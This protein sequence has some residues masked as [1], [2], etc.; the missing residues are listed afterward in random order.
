MTSTALAFNCPHFFII[1]NRLTVG[2]RCYWLAFPQFLSKKSP[3]RNRMPLW[4]DGIVPCNASFKWVNYFSL[5]SVFAFGYVLS[6]PG[7][8]PRDY[9]MRRAF[10]LAFEMVHRSSTGNSRRT[11]L[12]ESTI[13]TFSVLCWFYGLK[14][15]FARPG[16]TAAPFWHPGFGEFKAIRRRL[17]AS[18]P[19]WQ[20]F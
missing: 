6:D 20:L 12:Y 3:P 11:S 10:H 15:P 9:Q 19:L 14:L 7:L 8:S 17:L 13:I 4:I 2:V 5:A 16:P 1:Y 18:V